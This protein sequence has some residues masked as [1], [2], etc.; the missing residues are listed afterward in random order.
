M[1]SPKSPIQLIEEII[2]AKTALHLRLAAQRNDGEDEIGGKKV[3]DMIAEVD[4][5]IPGYEQMLVYFKNKMAADIMAAEVNDEP[6]QPAKKDEE[7][8]VGQ[9]IAARAGR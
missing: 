4:A 3:S 9:T 1:R 5:G 6:E 7:P 2:R 8:L